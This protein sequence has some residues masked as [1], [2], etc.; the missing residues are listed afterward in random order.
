MSECSERD[1]VDR[2]ESR[3]EV[4]KIERFSSPKSRRTGSWCGILKQNRVL[5]FTAHCS[6]VNAV[7][8][9]CSPFEAISIVTSLET[10]A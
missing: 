7:K 3:N 10:N 8:E 9:Q 6:Y 4:D 2:I 1:V 5:T